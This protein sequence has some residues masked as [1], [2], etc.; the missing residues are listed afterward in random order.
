MKLNEEKSLK[1]KRTKIALDKIRA[2]TRSQETRKIF[3]KK[4]KCRFNSIMKIWIWLLN[5]AK[6]P[7]HN[8]AEAFQ[9]MNLNTQNWDSP[10]K[11]LGEMQIKIKDMNNPQSVSLLPRLGVTTTKSRNDNLLTSLDTSNHTISFQDKNL[12]LNQVSTPQPLMMRKRNDLYNSRRLTGCAFESDIK[13]F[14]QQAQL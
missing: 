14:N 9:R 13:L 5:I 1:L 8:L 2:R 3:T 10:V 4:R 11:R 6:K 7:A 12:F